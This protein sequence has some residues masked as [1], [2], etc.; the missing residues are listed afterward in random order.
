MERLEILEKLER[1]DIAQDEASEL[2][3]QLD[4]PIPDAAPPTV[5]R[6]APGRSGLILLLAL[7][8]IPAGL[9]VLLVVA[10]LFFKTA[11]REQEVE[12]IRQAE[13]AQYEA[14]QHKAVMNEMKQQERRLHELQ[15]GG[16]AGGDD[17]QPIDE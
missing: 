14:M 10:L 9:V 8:A 16:S 17:K 11:A 15:K 3:A 12:A 2:L 13:A 1:G 4:S 7:A 5:Q 6:P